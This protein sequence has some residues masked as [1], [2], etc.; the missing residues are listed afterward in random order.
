MVSYTCNG[1]FRQCSLTSFKQ[2]ARY[3]GLS[4]AEDWADRD[5][6]GVVSTSPQRRPT[7]ERVLE[8][9]SRVEEQ[10][11]GLHKSCL[12]AANTGSPRGDY[13]IV[14][15]FASVPDDQAEALKEEISVTVHRFLG[16]ERKPRE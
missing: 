7:A 14:A 6:Y 15:A 11:V 5:E 9:Y 4:F 2:W 1:N 13:G 16:L 3:A 10:A 12:I 8:D